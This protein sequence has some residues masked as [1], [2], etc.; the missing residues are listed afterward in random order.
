MAEAVTCIVGIEHDGRVTLGGDSAVTDEDTGEIWIQRDP[1]VFRVGSYVI[2]VSGSNYVADILRYRFDPPAPEDSLDRFMRC[3]FI[4]VVR[5]ALEDAG[6]KTSENKDGDDEDTG[7][8]FSA[9][10]GVCGKLYGIDDD[11]A[12][13]SPRQSFHAV[14][15]GS[16]PARTMMQTLHG[17]TLTPEQKLT[18]ALKASESICWSVRRPWK[19]VTSPI[20]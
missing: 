6:H 20:V 12:V 16:Q 8:D 1:K 5:K 11:L 2:G 18:E 7:A 3:E 15:D 4:P 9:L 17:A 19:F 13:H 14:G 10:V